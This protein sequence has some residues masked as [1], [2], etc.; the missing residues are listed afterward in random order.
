M[1]KVHSKWSRKCLLL[2]RGNQE[3]N[4]VGSMIILIVGSSVT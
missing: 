1:V 2:K 4:L 3:V